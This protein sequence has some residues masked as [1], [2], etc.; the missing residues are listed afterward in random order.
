MVDRLCQKAY[1]VNMTGKSY[2][3]R[4]TQNMFKIIGN[5]KRVIYLRKTCSGGPFFKSKIGKKFTLLHTP[6]L[7]EYVTNYVHKHLKS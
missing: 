1:L 5:V 6:E 4:D 3:I 7:K 2:R